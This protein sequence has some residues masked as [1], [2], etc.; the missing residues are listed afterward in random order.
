MTITAVF[1]YADAMAKM[2]GKVEKAQKWLDAQVI[3]DSNYF[4]PMDTGTLMRSA[5]LSTQLGSGVVMWKT[6]YADTRYFGQPETGS[7][8]NPNATNM[9]FETA[10]A[11][12]GK[13]W[14]EKVDAII[15]AN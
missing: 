5:Q 9:W 14:V 13:S 8:R 3:T 6:P 15:K 10:K 11:R 12:Y 4:C 2:Q 7:T 1:D